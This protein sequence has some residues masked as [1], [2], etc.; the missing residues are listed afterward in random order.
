MDTIPGD[1]WAAEYARWIRLNEERLGDASAARARKASSNPNQASSALSYF[2]HAV[3]L[4]PTDA[5]SKQPI[6]SK[7]MS[8]RLNPHN[9]YYLL[10][11]FE[12][13]GLPVG[14]LDIQIPGS[15]RPTSYFSFVSAASSS[16]RD[17][18]DTMSMS[19]F[20]STMTAMSSLSLAP[21]SWWRSNDSAP[22]A[23]P[24]RDIK[25]I[26]SAL[27]KVPALRIGPIPPR[28]IQDFEDCP[29]QNAVPLDVFK[30]LQLLDVDDVD[31]RTL[32]G[33]DRLSCQLRSLACNK[34]GIEDVSELLIDL[35][36]CDMARRRGE[37][38]N[39]RKRIVH[40]SSQ[41]WDDGSHQRGVE[42]EGGERQEEEVEQQQQLPS[43]TSLDFQ[44][45]PELPSLTWHF[46]RYLNLSNNNLTFV[47]TAPM[48]LLEG[49]TNLDL[50]SNLL[51]TVPPALSQLANLTSLNVSDNLID[52]VLGIYGTL[53]SIKV[54]NLSKNRLESLCGL[55]R[56][57]TLQRVDLRSNAV[58][59][60][61]EV[62][63]LATLPSIAEVWVAGNPMVDE[64]IN[65]RV[66]CFVEFAKEGRLILLDGEAPGWMEK[67]KIQER[68]PGATLCTPS[69]VGRNQDAKMSPEAAKRSSSI[70]PV[71]TVKHKGSVS[72]GLRGDRAGPPPPRGGSDASASRNLANRA[73]VERQ[74]ARKRNRRVVDLDTSADLER[75]AAATTE[76]SEYS[77]MSDSDAVKKAALSAVVAA[78]QDPAARV[79]VLSRPNGGAAAMARRSKVTA[80][81][82]EPCDLGGALTTT[83]TTFSSDSNTGRVQ[84]NPRPTGG[85]PSAFRTME[86]LP[87][88]PGPVRAGGGVE[89]RS[90]A[91]RRKIEALK[92]EVGDDWLRLLSRG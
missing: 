22:A 1:K 4:A 52:S 90:E 9:L 35:V 28:L 64:L 82:Y 80:S 14:S 36:A 33:W 8:L 16:A 67:Q 66:D 85:A 79:R 39:K 73:V 63:R 46:L 58:F 13:L 75:A 60:A 37:K 62:G 83:T 40:H 91:F 74:Q 84:A 34:S 77:G 18:D 7:P 11:R 5:A 29:G 61:G 21:S 12:A 78:D 55:E 72:K 54:L 20:R 88:S 50:S 57:Y 53:K 26:Y 24:A 43:R 49:L 42:I 68:V 51:N 23:D 32:S 45:L 48:A 15:A 47:P 38:P 27:T 92:G 10:I 56:L 6:V 59:D 3:G 81:L 89:G 2:W 69:T 17:R 70:P 65:H 86:D 19:S 25:Y 71:K 31:P 87:H 44:P 76:E 41:G 30:N